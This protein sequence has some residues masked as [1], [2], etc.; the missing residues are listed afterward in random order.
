MCQLFLDRELSGISFDDCVFV[1]DSPNDEP[2]F[3]AFNRSVGVANV[4]AFLSQMK[5]S[6]KFVTASDSADGF[7]EVVDLVLGK[8][9]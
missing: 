8:I 7:C 1:G 6:P 5:S 4:R 9:K 2:M 3:A